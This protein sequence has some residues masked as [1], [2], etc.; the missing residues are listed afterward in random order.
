VDN[1]G[2]GYGAGCAKEFDC[3]DADAGINPGATEVCNNIDD[4]CDTMVDDQLS[5]A[6]GVSDIGACTLGTERCIGGVWSSCTA[7]LPSEEICNNLDDNCDG[8]IDEGCDQIA[9]PEEDSLRR[10]LDSKFG[11]GNYS[12]TEFKERFDATKRFINIQK[13]AKVEAGKT[14]VTIDIIPIQGVKNLDVF[15]YIPKSIAHSVDN[16]VFT[17]PPEVIQPDPLVAW[18]FVEL[19]AKSSVGYELSS[20]VSGAD[21]MTEVIPIAESVEPLSRPWYFNLLPLLIIPVLGF[22]FVFLVEMAHRNR[23]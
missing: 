11:A 17:S 1:D 22:I 12:F 13:S 23:K 14:K 16:V 15:V 9:S 3:D 2:D 5:R 20:E 6:C 18:H 19:T 10:V 7:I 21:E 4:D 8:R